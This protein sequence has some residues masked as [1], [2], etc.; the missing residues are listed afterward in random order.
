MIPVINRALR[1][2]KKVI[3][4]QTGTDLDL[5]PGSGAAGGIGGAFHA[6]LGAELVSGF[7]LVREILHLDRYMK[8][9]DFVITGEGMIDEKSYHGKAAMQVLKMAHSN[10]KPVILVVAD[11]VDNAST[12]K[13]YGVIRVYALTDRYTKKYAMKHARRLLREIA[14]DIGEDLAAMKQT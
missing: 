3:L 8:Q 13:E 2:F 1:K 5:I 9:A 10:K 14:H 7:S 11:T 12:Y 6:L 4:A